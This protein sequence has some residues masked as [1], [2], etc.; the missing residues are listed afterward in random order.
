MILEQ[1]DEN[2]LFLKENEKAC[3]RKRRWK[4]FVFEQ[5]DGIEAYVNN[6]FFVVGSLIS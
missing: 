3:L 4:L 1:R 2:N 5:G 6:L